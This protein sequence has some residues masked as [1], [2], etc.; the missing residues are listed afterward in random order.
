MTSTPYARKAS[1]S[2]PAPATQTQRAVAF[3]EYGDPSVLRLMD[4]PEPHARAGQ[5]RVRMRAAG[6]QPFDCAF[7]RGDLRGFMPATFP[8]VLGNDFAGIVDEVGDGVSGVQIGDEVLGY[9]TLAAH[10]ELI[11]VD[12]G[13]VVPR[14]RTMPW[15]VAGGLSA[16][17]QTALNAL[18][19][20]GVSAGETLLVHA[21]AGGVGTVAVQL[22]REWGATVIGTASPGNHSWLGSLGITPV[23]YGPGL[24]DRVRALA[25]Q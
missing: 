17:G 5:V 22:A 18:R 4:F 25:P 21:A 9:C 7:R 10:A 13:A 12:A 8:Q 11:V 19:D 14:P 16:S 23:T 2:L 1:S 6:V 20:L 3:S 15:E 24:V